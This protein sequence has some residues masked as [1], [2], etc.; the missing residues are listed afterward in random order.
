[1]K[2]PVELANLFTEAALKTRI[3]DLLAADAEKNRAECHRLALQLATIHTYYELDGLLGATPPVGNE[4]AIRRTIGILQAMCHLAPVVNEAP[5]RQRF[6]AAF[7]GL[8]ELIVA[9]A[10]AGLIGY[11]AR[12]FIATATAA[13]FAAS[14]VEQLR[15]MCEKAVHGFGLREDGEQLYAE[16]KKIDQERGRHDVMSPSQRRGVRLRI[17][18][19]KERGRTQVR[20]LR[21]FVRSSTVPRSSYRNRLPARSSRARRAPR[22]TVARRAQADSGGASDGSPD[23]PGEPPSRR[24]RSRFLA[25][26]RA[27][28]LRCVRAAPFPR[29]PKGGRVR[30]AHGWGHRG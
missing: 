22:R 12:E 10:K 15:W 6:L 17:Q 8:L 28:E 21:R 14:V 16:L 4:P 5:S 1:M 3:S 11:A 7:L 20:E 29:P 25:W 18:G 2:C 13:G 24:R 19:V 30:V 27:P 26:G 23:G 9:R